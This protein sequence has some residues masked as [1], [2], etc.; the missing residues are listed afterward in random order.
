MNWSGHKLGPKWTYYAWAEMDVTFRS[1]CPKWPWNKTSV[2]RSW[3]RSF[4]GNR[5]VPYARRRARVNRGDVGENRL[6]RKKCTIKHNS[7]KFSFWSPIESTS[8]HIRRWMP[9]RA[10]TMR[11]GAK[12][13]WVR[14]Q[15]TLKLTACNEEISGSVLT[16]KVLCVSC[17]LSC[18]RQIQS[19]LDF[20][21]KL[22]S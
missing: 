19:S 1:K 9:S 5:K 11:S 15:I 13:Q 8:R 21:N 10:Y 14:G 16:L 3:L 6:Y 17:I 20:I 2:D 22:S 4:P 7:H 18:I 12:P